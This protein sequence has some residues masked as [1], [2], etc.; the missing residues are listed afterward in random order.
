MGSVHTHR[1]EP[2]NN[3][4]QLI[5]GVT[6]MADQT[7]VM[8]NGKMDWRN[9]PGSDKYRKESVGNSKGSQV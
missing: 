9:Y 5:T 6:Y 4:S 1:T 3:P 7:G 8:A 2:G